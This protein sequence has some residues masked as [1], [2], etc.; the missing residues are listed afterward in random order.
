MSTLYKSRQRSQSSARQRSE[1][2]EFDVVIEIPK[3]QRSK[4]EM[5][6]ETGRIR[7]D[8]ML[9]TSTR[10]PADYG[11]VEHTLADDG[12]R[13]MRLSCSTSRPSPAV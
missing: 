10:Y 5:D 13:W 7:L 1:I 11:F 6:H 9:F 3:G 4:Y 8:R 12:D 2:V